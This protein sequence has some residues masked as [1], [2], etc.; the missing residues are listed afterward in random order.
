MLTSCMPLVKVHVFGF[1]MYL[2]IE[3]STRGYTDPWWLNI[4]LNIPENARSI[5]NI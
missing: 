1:Q 2:N 5:E 3:G 4:I